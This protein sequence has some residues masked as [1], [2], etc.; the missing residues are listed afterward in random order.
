MIST[1]GRSETPVQLLAPASCA[2][3]AAATSTWIDVSKTKGDL[4]FTVN[5][6]AV[7]G[8]IAPKIRT[9]TDNSGTGAADLD[10]NEGAWTTQTTANHVEQRTAVKNATKGFVQFVGTIVTG[11]VLV[12]VTIGK[13]AT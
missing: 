7:T 8:S 3:T 12:G 9:A 11:P 6:G 13:T 5:I 10:M 4:V 2:N 1:S